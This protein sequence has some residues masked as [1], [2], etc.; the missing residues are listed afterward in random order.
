MDST[1]KEENKNSCGTFSFITTLCKKYI[2]M[3]QKEL[4][5]LDAP[6][7]YKKRESAMNGW[8]NVIFKM[9]LDGHTNETIYF[10]IK[11][12]PDFNESNRTL[13]NYIYLM[14]KKFPGSDTV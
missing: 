9:M 1:G 10:Y 4:A 8:L 2:H 3:S 13:E 12:Q 11:G 7:K 6:K 5:E 14:G